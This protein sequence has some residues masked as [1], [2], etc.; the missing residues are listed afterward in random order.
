[1]NRSWRDLIGGIL[2]V[3]ASHMGFW[4]LTFAVFSTIFRSGNV[5]GNMIGS[6]LLIANFILGITQLAYLIPIARY[7]GRR[8]RSAVVKGIAIGAV[9]TILLNGSCYVWA[10]IDFGGGLYS[11]IGMA[12]I[13]LILAAMAFSLINEVE[14]Q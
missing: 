1:M 4:L 6:T 8:Q 12:T 9:I 7:F 10:S 5:I 3:L 14:K 11:F 13:T 2:L